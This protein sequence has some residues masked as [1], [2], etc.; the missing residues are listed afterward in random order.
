MIRKT[1]FDAQTT[2][3]VGDSGYR[4]IKSD[5]LRGGLAPSKKLKIDELRKTYDLGAGTVREI[6]TRLWVEGLVVAEGQKGFEVAPVTAEGLRDVGRLRLLLEE[7]ALRQSIETGDMHWEA[8][9]VRAHYMLSTVEEKLIAGDRSIVNDWVQQDW[10]F[11]YA[12]ISACNSPALMAAHSMAF[13]RFIRYHM[14]VLEFRGRPAADQHAELRE[15]VIARK[16][17][18]AVD[19]LGRHIRSGVDHIL[20]TGRIP[21]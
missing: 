21:G 7:Q 2:D 1:F 4:R 6:L 18:A 14:L 9:V 10:E 17:D 5:I 19:L 13:D 3:T 8:D 12:T 16:T 20:S 15:L 11:H